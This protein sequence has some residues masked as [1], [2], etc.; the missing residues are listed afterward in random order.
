MTLALRTNAK[1][2][3]FLRVLGR[4]PDGFHDVETIL[5]SVR[6]ADELVVTAGDELS[7]EMRVVDGN[8]FERPSLE[9]NLVWRAAQ[10]APEGARRVTIEVVKRIPVGAGLGGGSANAAG[11]LRALAELYDLGWDD[12]TMRRLGA[13]LGSDV[14]FCVSGG[15]AQATGRGEQIRSLAFDGTLWFVLGISREPLATRDVYEA[16]DRLGRG[17]GPDAS[18]LL[19]ALAQ[20]DPG[21]IAAAVHNDL[22]A[23]ACSL[24]PELEEKLESMAQA[25][26]ATAAVS[27]SGPTIF[28]LAENQAHARR[29][30]DTVKDGFHRVEVVRSAPTC[31]ETF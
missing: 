21:G 31:V 25:G 29:I 11:T 13:E 22:Q 6:L 14:P 5:Q 18:G 12:A 10:L 8:E 24:R 16:W 17:S 19:D 27:G 4:R 3:L 30:A 2:N 7:V 1:V 28:G 23:A 26:A 20:G 9:D 15:T